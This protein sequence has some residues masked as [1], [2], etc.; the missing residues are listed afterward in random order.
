M[1]Q[2]HLDARLIIDARPRKRA[3]TSFVMQCVCVGDNDVYSF[4]QVRF[5]DRCAECVVAA[6]M[7]GH[8][9]AWDAWMGVRLLQ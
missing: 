4:V 1:A 2:P 9:H 5:V 8:D 7:L 3:P 6:F